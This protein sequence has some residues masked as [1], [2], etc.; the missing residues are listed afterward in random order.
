MSW[1]RVE[2][3]GDVTIVRLERH[4]KLN[5][6]STAF[7][8]EILT[9]IASPEVRAAKC[10]VFVGG[11]RAFSAGADLTEMRGRSAGEVMAY[12]QDTGDVY[13]AIAALPMP[14]ISVL[15]G[16]CLGGGL[17]LAL[18]TDFRVAEATAVLGFPEVSIG[19]L[20]SSGGLW[21]LTQMVGPARAREL[22]VWRTRFSA[23]EAREYGLVTEVVPPGDGFDRGLAMAEALVKLPPMAVAV[24]LRCIDAMAEAGSKQAGLWLERLGYAALSQEMTSPVGNGGD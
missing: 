11:P 14:K 4:E 15:Q 23:A 1:V 22:A 24:T 10:V 20:P 7:E 13:E 18:A 9:A 19:I 8:R 16:Y 3:R 2:P 6:L 21:R 17:E 5:A 12:Y